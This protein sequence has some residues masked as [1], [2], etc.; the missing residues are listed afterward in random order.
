MTRHAVALQ[1]VAYLKSLAQAALSEESR[2]PYSDPQIPVVPVEEWGAMIYDYLGGDVG[3]YCAAL[4][5]SF[6]LG[7]L[8]IAQDVLERHRPRADYADTCRDCLRPWPCLSAAPWL[9]LLAPEE[10]DRG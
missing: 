2:R 4:D 1:R 8:S 9:A 6:A 3:T 10:T 7:L 5:P